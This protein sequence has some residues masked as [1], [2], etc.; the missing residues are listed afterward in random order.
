MKIYNQ[1]RPT[2]KNIS[3]NACEWIIGEHSD[4]PIIAHTENDVIKVTNLKMNKTIGGFKNI[5]QAIKT[6]KQAQ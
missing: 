2:R 1:P 4:Y 5:Q 3:G 6:L